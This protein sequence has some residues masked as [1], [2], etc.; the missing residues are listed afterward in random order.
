MGVESTFNLKVYRKNLL[1]V[2]FES[3]KLELDYFKNLII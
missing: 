2:E 3:L 1:R